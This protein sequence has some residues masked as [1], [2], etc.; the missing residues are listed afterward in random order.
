MDWDIE[1]YV[2]EIQWYFIVNN[3]WVFYYI[4]SIADSTASSWLKVC[5]LMSG[6][7]RVT[8]EARLE[9]KPNNPR[10]ENKTP[11]HQYSYSFQT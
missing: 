10:L 4:M 6:E 8:M 5:L 1:Y 2:P 9:T 11:S 7:R 3:N